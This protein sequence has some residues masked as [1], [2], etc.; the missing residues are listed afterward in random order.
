MEEHEGDLGAYL[1]LVPAST[2]GPVVHPSPPTHTQTHLDFL[3]GGIT[4][5]KKAEK[6][7]VTYRRDKTYDNLL[8]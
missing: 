1:G 7:M 2:S 8:S 5:N 3:D 4:H 6:R